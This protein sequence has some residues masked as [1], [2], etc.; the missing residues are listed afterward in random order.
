MKTAGKA[1]D[2]DQHRV[3]EDVPVED[4][5]LVEA[6]GAGGEHILLADLLEERILGQQR[7]RSKAADDQRRE[8]QRQMPEIVQDPVPPVQLRPIAGDEPAQREPLEV[9]A[10]GEQDD[11]EHGEQEARHRIADRDHGA[12]PQ[13]E[14]APVA[15][16]LANAQRDRDQIG[17]QRRPQAQGDRDRQLLDDQ[18][19]DRPALEEA[20]AEIE[21]GEAAQHVEEADIGRLV[22]AVEL[23]ELV[24]ELGLD[25]AG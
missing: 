25:A 14:A 2:H 9:A 24:D 20:L 11:Q 15:D 5:P 1:G 7:E 21:R 16:R 18:V 10:P 17:D 22:E 13:V 8:W 19:G 23:L 6:L 3:A 4:A 12:G